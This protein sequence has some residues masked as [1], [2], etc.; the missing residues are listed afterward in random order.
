MDSLG[1][2]ILLVMGK[3][4]L[5]G[6]ANSRPF[7]LKNSIQHYAWGSCG[8]QAFIAHLLGI[9]PREDTPYAELWMGVHP[10]A[11]SHV[12]DPDKTT[13]T[14]ADWLARAPSEHLGPADSLASQNN[15]PYLL[16]VLSADQALSIQTH[17]NKL[18]AESL[19]ANDPEHY[20]D[21]NHK[22]EIAIAID[23][24]DALIGFIDQS[25]FPDLLETIPEIRDLLSHDAD[26]PNTLQAAV[27]YLLKLSTNQDKVITKA[28]HSLYDRLS[29]QKELGETERLF[30]GLVKQYGTSDIGLI[31]LF[32]LNRVR[33]GPG[34]AVYLPPGV[35]HAYLRG[36]IIEC[37]ANSDNVVRLG[38][39]PK[40]CDAEALAQTLD[41][42]AGTDFS[43]PTSSDGYLTE[44]QTPTTEFFVKSLDL[45]QGESRA[46]TLR[47]SLTMFLLLDGEVSL[48]WGDGTKVCTCVYR[49]GDSFI[50]PANLHDF[51][52]QA[53]N[54][55]KLF[56]VD[57]PKI[58]A[59]IQR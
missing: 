50:A 44:Y 10:K 31:F 5:S 13:V 53:K 21:D 57:L 56:L 45:L 6:C 52:I 46:F 27:L 43:V 37:M 34:E 24:L 12:I 2:V 14:L 30:L 1:P 7:R 16:K 3:S 41:F 33:L 22:P 59:P 4:D 58:P 38:L 25:H 49:R 26:E 42:D 23:Y 20:P 51:T 17:P 8:D 11:P 47:D 28:I 9:T 55:S 18:Q 40:F 48:R 36:N 19:H 15:L 29:T 54:H 39:T 32:F 35:P